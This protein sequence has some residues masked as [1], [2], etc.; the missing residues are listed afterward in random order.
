M[1]FDKIKKRWPDAELI[2][3]SG[4]YACISLC[5]G[6]PTVSLHADHR[7]AIGAVIWLNRYGCGG[8]CT[9]NHFAMTFAR[10]PRRA[11]APQ[12]DTQH[13]RH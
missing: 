12:K 6:A 11:R 3:G 1:S 10:T 9:G 4:P 2:E 13:A 8:A 5:G 7:A